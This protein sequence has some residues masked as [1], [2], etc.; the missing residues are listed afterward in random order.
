Y[1]ASSVVLLEAGSVPDSVESAI[2]E[3][4]AF[5]HSLL[6][7]LHY[8]SGVIKYLS[9]DDLQS[10]KLSAMP[11]ID[12]AGYA[13]NNEKRR[14][15]YFAIDHLV[16]N[17]DDL[18]DEISLPS[19]A[20]FGR[21]HVDS[22]LC[23]LCM[24]CTSVCPTTAVQAGNDTPRL[25]FVES[26]CVQCGLCQTACPEQAIQLQPRLLTDPEKRRSKIVLH[27]EKPF[28]CVTCGKPFATQSIINNIM[29]KLSE[30]AMFQSDRSRQRLKMCEDCRVVDAVQDTEAM[31]AGLV[32]G[33]QDDSVN[34]V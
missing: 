12:I 28:N 13:G 2:K 6:K 15:L 5:S 3:Q 27:E 17:A 21:I 33:G 29:S 1:G 11:E 31:Q 22:E 19:N 23:T 14:T 34:G 30:H 8:D 10:L 32:A 9:I 18:I 16:R 25:V 24:G 26:I 4:L 20:P 7:G